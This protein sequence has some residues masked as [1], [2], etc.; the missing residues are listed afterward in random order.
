MSVLGNRSQE[1]EKSIKKGSEAQAYLAYSRNRLVEKWVTG[2]G[3]GGETRARLCRV[4]QAIIRDSGFN[5]ELAGTP[6]KGSKKTGDMICFHSKKRK[7]RVWSGS[8]L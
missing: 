5:S 8:V 1:R 7:G 6:L 3:V 2:A 4:L